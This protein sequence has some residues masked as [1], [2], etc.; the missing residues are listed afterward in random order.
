MT[1]IH[2]SFEKRVKNYDFAV[3]FWVVSSRQF[4]EQL[5]LTSLELFRDANPTITGNV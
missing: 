1:V 4:F 2:I 5:Y 3:F